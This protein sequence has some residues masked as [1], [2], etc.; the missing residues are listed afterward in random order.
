MR[1][2][3]LIGAQASRISRNER[4][5][6]DRRWR[7]P[8]SACAPRKLESEKQIG[9]L[10]GANTCI[11]LNLSFFH[12]PC[13]IHVCRRGRA[14][15]DDAAAADQLIAQQVRQQERAEVVRG[16]LTSKPSLV[17]L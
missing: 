13:Q 9:R 10:G 8:P 2:T 3:T 7:G 14:D 11:G 17:L 15:C 4:W 6:G 5:P 1:V 12:Q 16:Q